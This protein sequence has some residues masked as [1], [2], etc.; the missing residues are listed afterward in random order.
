MRKEE[1]F[2]ERMR[3]CNQESMFQQ[4]LEYLEKKEKN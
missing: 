4:M 3:S 2:E 1:G